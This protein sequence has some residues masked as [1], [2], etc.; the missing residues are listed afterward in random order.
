MLQKPASAV[1]YEKELG[2]N[3]PG[4][5]HFKN[6]DE[7]RE[8][9]DTITFEEC[10]YCNVKLGLSFSFADGKVVDVYDANES[11]VYDDRQVS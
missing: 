3:D 5:R 7:V 9:L 8:N 11:P 6:I 2:L 10:H 4:I 1:A